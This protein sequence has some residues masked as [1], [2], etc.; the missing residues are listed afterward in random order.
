[1]LKDYE[2]FDYLIK[3]K[4]EI[5]QNDNFFA[6]STD[7]LLLANFCKIS[8]NRK[9]RCVDLCAGNG[10]IPLLLSHKT[11]GQIQAVEIQE[12]LVDMGRR[13]VA[14]NHLSEQIHYHHLDIKVCVPYL[15][16]S[17]YDYVTCNPPY[18]PK[19]Q[20]PKQK[21]KEAHAIARHELLC[22]LEDCVR[23]GSLLL[24]QGGKFV[25]VHRAYRISDL[26]VT[27]TKY[28]LAP[29]RM[30]FVYSSGK[31]SQATMVL[32]EAI[33]DGFVGSCLVEKPFYIYDD[34]GEYSEEMKYI[35]YG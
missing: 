19:E 15:K 9:T 31:D 2:R 26:I 24:K 21:M 23:V 4:L 11:D 20:M 6:M 13:S 14:H 18:F 25:I 8:K 3:E 16:Q 32:I 5:I 33:Y 22:T 7:A 17:Y 12:A 35:Y 29:K 1:M 10:V 30:Q 28:K 27:L 34:K